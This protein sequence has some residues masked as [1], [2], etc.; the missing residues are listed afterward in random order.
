MV[1]RLDIHRKLQG[2]HQA[3]ALLGE[4]GKVKG[5]FNNV[6]N[7]AELSAMVEDIRDAMIDYQVCTLNHPFLPCLKL[8]LDI[9]ATRH[10]RQQPP[11]GR[12]FHL[13]T[14]RPW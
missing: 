1:S 10:I 8:L 11:T 13:I 4:Q 3:L 14:F 2:V 7:A 12:E 9:N 6:V 5:F